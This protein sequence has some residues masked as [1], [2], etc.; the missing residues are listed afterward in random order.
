[1]SMRSDTDDLSHCNAAGRCQQAGTRLSVAAR[2]ACGLRRFARLDLGELCQ[3]F[4]HCADD[5]L[6]GER[7]G[8]QYDAGNDN[9][10]TSV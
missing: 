1:M 2:A 6:S 3:P 5:G 8:R 10:A 9:G 7:I 4:G